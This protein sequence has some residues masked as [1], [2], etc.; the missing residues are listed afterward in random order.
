M[1][2]HRD[3]LQRLARTIRFEA[4]ACSTSASHDVD[5]EL[6]G[7]AFHKHTQ[8]CGL[9][10]RSPPLLQ[11]F[12]HLLHTLVTLG[13][14][15]LTFRV[16]L[17]V[18]DRLLSGRHPT[19]FPSPHLQRLGPEFAAQCHVRRIPGCRDPTTRRHF[20]ELP[21]LW[22]SKERPSTVLLPSVSCP[23]RPLLRECDPRHLTAKPN[24]PSIPAVPPGFDGLLHKRPCRFVSPCFR[25]WGPSRFQPN[26]P[27]AASLQRSVP[28]AFLGLAYRT[29]RSVPLRD[30][31]TVSP[32]P[33]PS[34]RC[35]PALFPA[36]LTR[37]QGFAPSR[38]P[39]LDDDVAIN[40]K[41]DASLGLVPLQ[42]SPLT[43]ERSIEFLLSHPAKAASLWVRP[44][45]AGSP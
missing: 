19:L 22:F 14:V 20:I 3:P 7:V 18:C 30:S 17:E 38:S 12:W 29:L 42:G 40:V 11:L 2:I 21:L 41:L 15:R 31:R 5:G 32:Q 36:P 10:Q 25:P 4:T 45:E 13:A 9:L 28:W 43:L 37:P 26:L 1:R 8:R 16:T 27:P 44:A 23:S 34:R 39:F 24:A 6:R 33:F 35:L